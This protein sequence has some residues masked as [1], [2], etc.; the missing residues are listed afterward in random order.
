MDLDLARE[1]YFRTLDSKDQQDARLG[2]YVALLSVV[3]GAL[4]VLVRWAWPPCTALGSVGLGVAI[5]AAV[6][7][8]AAVV[9]A[10]RVVGYDYKR[11]PSP[12]DMLAHREELDAFHVENPK[13]EGKASDEFAEDLLRQMAEAATVNSANNDARSERFYQVSVMLLIVV[14]LAAIVAALL[15][16]NQAWSVLF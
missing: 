9:W 5:A 12:S 7:Y 10:L 14:I 11:L 15:G 13:A 16:L 4:T 1:I 3:G 2:V 8:F 6:L